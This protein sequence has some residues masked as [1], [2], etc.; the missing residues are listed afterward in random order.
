MKF[1]HIIRNVRD[2]CD[3]LK[4]VSWAPEGIFDLIPRIW[5][6]SNC[7]LNQSLRGKPNYCLVKY[8]RLISYFDD[9]I[10]ELC[11]FLGVSMD[12]SILDPQV[13]IRRLGMLPHN[14]NLN[15]MVADVF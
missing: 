5:S 4:M 15:K 13:R 3:S 12:V 10:E 1:I 7:H 2:I 8:E 14:A 11:D 9:T 6:C